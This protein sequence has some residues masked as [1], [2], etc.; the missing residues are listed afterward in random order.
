MSAISA[1][2]LDRGHLH[3]INEILSR[4]GYLSEGFNINLVK[5][6]ESRERDVACTKHDFQYSVVYVGCFTVRS[7]SF[8]LCIVVDS[9]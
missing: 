4:L 8:N 7:V 2:T 6:I 5:L 1:V 3:F 9:K